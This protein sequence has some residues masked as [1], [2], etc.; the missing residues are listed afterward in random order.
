MTKTEEMV[1]EAI[2]DTGRTPTQ[3]LKEMGSFGPGWLHPLMLALHQLEREGLITRKVAKA[4]KKV[5][6]VRVLT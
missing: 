1:Y 4:T 2:G 6:W 3:I 5:R